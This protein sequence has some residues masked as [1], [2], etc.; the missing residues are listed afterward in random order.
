[1]SAIPLPSHVHYELLLQL[2]ERQSILAVE[3]PQHRDEMQQLIITLRKAA[4]LQQQLEET[5]ERDGLIVE[6]HW[7]LNQTDP[8]LPNAND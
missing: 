4:V 5:L 7:S 6:Y 3:K 2:L 8:P 1:M